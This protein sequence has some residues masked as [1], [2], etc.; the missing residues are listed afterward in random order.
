MDDWIK[1]SD[2]LPGD[3]LDGMC[4][5]VAVLHFQRGLIADADV[6]RKGNPASSCPKGSF[7]FWANTATHWQPLPAPPTE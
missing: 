6:W 3:E 4:V 2:R 7:A 5:I 1:C